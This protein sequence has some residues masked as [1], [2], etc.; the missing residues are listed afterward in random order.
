MSLNN[1]LYSENYTGLIPVL[2]RKYL[3]KN[4]GG[5]NAGGMEMPVL[6]LSMLLQ[7]GMCFFQDEKAPA[8]SNIHGTGRHKD[9]DLRVSIILDEI[10]TA[11]IIMTGPYGIIL[12]IGL[13]KHRIHKELILDLDPK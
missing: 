2:F 5:Y 12:I 9:Q 10:C 1:G 3:Y 11:W 7:K 8:F 4:P 13:N 6:Q